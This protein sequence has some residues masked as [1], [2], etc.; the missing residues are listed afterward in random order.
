MM[1]PALVAADGV[2]PLFG[3]ASAS[4]QPMHRGAE[5]RS[6]ALSN[7]NPP[8]ASADMAALRERRLIANRA[9]DLAR[10]NP[11]AIAAITRLV[12]MI[13]GAGLRFS[14][15]PSA[16]AL[17]IT[18]DQALDLGKQI[19][20][21]LARH[22]ND[23]RKRWDAQRKVSANGLYRLMARSFVKLDEACVVATWREG[24]GPYETAFLA[25]DPERLANPTWKSDSDT[26][27]GGVEIDGY[28]A[29]V[30][31]HIRNRHPGDGFGSGVSWERVPRETAWGRPVFCHVFEPEREDQN[32]PI[33]PFAALM[34]I[35][36]MKGT[37]SELEL[38]AAA[39]NA[40]YA[41]YIKSNLPFAEV[42]A[43]MEP[44]AFNS[45]TNSYADKRLDFYE[46]APV[47][48]GGVRVP[49]LPVGDE[50]SMAGQGRERAGMGEFD[51]IFN[52]QIAARMGMSRQ[53]VLM[54]FAKLNYS[55][56]RTVLNETWRMVR[57]KVASFVEQGPIPMALCVVEEAID[58]GYIRMPPRCRPL[59][60]EPAGWMAGRWIGPGRGWVDPVKE[61]ESAS[62]RME[63]MVST[64]EMECAEQGL[65]YEEVLDQIQREEAEITSRGLTRA[66]VISRIAA[67][68]AQADPAEETTAP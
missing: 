60:D 61:A 23:P 50:I 24:Q 56:S 64:L 16:A 62:L 30:A 42:A 47:K 4:A 43:S 53:Q 40:M 63:T 52:D 58:K 46:A 26:L 31:Y 38:A 37:L 45:A 20:R 39:V 36:R 51:D 25:V 7:W 49:V 2:T 17:G 35:L 68:S 59:W 29:P 9:E 32:R 5:T 22:A 48:I 27:R 15:K 66:T 1:R 19:E 65:D 67:R 3:Q 12:D 28:G 54:N 34:P 21:E 14:S 13:V 10:N 44:E 41:T 33:S 8:G 6:Q 57:R 11:I 55:S 18:R